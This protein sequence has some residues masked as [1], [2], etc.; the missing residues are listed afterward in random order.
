[1]NKGEGKAYEKKI[2]TVAGKLNAKKELSEEESKIREVMDKTKNYLKIYDEVEG[3]YLLKIFNRL[4]TSDKNRKKSV[5]AV[6]L[7][8]GF[9]RRSVIRHKKKILQIFAVIFQNEA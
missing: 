7:E 2:K 5:L 3:T 9:S 8:I 6:A 1:M 4:F